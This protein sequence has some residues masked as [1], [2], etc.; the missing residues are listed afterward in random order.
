MR[1][2]STGGHTNI[3]SVH[4]LM[5]QSTVRYG[6][7]AKGMIPRTF[8]RTN[9]STLKELWRNM[10]RFKPSTMTHTNE[11][12]IQRARRENYAFV[13]EDTIANYV[14]MLNPCDLITIDR[15]LFR[16][17]YALALPKKSRWFDAIDTGINMLKRS[18]TLDTLYMKWWVQTS[19]C[20]SER[21]SS[22]SFSL[23]ATS[24]SS[25][26]YHRYMVII[27]AS[28]HLSILC[29]NRLSIV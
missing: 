14:S 7:L 13:L 10:N 8:K 23:A 24:S 22:R 4:D 27:F 16:R 5:N 2:P 18:N 12:G 25:V 9:D 15:F 28:L 1:K 17:N 20:N 19:K 29:A 11:E 21:P 6:T 26:D 3:Q